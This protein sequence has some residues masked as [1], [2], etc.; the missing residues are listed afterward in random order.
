M[1]RILAIAAALCVALAAW[2]LLARTRSPGVAAT[3]PPPAAAAP[4]AAEVEPTPE[5]PARPPD[6]ARSA[7]GEVAE[8]A[9]T[10]HPQAAAASAAED[11]VQCLLYGRIRTAGDE[12]VERRGVTLTDE[13]GVALRCDA[14]AD[15]TYSASGLHPGRWWLKPWASG[16]RSIVDVVDLTLERP[17][18]A[19]DFVLQAEEGAQVAVRVIAPSGEPFFAAL[20]RAGSSRANLGFTPV[21]TREPLPENL[22]SVPGS[23][24]Q[25]V[26][27]A[28]FKWTQGGSRRTLDLLGTLVLKERPPLVV[29][30]LLGR[31]VL[32]SQPLEPGVA[33]L[34]FTLDP[35]RFLGLL[36]SVRWRLVDA[37]SGEPLLEPRCRVEFDNGVM[38]FVKSDAEGWHLLEHLDP[39][40]LR[41]Q[42]GLAGYESLDL[43]IEPPPGRLT[44]LGSIPLGPEV[45]IRGRV[46]DGEGQPADV[47]LLCKRIDPADRFAPPESRHSWKVSDGAF[48]I[49][50]LA[51]AQ[52]LL[53]TSIDDGHD[54]VRPQLDRWMSRSVVVSTLA[55]PVEDVVLRLEPACLVVFLVDDSACIRCRFR[56]VEPS[57]FV[58]RQGT[59]YELGPRRLKLPPGPFTLEL[60]DLSGAKVREQA[61]EASDQP[62][63]VKVTLD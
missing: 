53:Q 44:D 42:S 14:F 59:F 39:V 48:E 4:G 34:V 50:G 47:A 17:V 31:A 56:V 28:E 21:A 41:I 7:E 32:A 54:P 20:E 29:S 60:Y 40:P 51:R 2:I 52:Y 63:H 10:A 16:Y 3:Q 38:M 6:P 5:P 33:E 9:E 37:Q 15:G 46:L 30:L 12:P 62:L 1:R 36:V 26:G 35:E 58:L 45:W 57:G 55:G 49:R 24:R 27:V 13:L 11:P 8:A 25:G 19:R 23:I 43:R 61:I 22:Y 18:L